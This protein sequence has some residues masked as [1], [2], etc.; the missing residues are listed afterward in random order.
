MKKF[1]SINR[2]INRGN[3]NIEMDLATG[4]PRLLRKTKQ[5]KW[6]IY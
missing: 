3:L 5:G 1:R 6:I 2:Q 4:Q